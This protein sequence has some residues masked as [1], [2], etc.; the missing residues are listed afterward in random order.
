MQVYD[1]KKSTFSH[2]GKLIKRRN[3]EGIPWEIE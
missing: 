2:T 1:N 3:E